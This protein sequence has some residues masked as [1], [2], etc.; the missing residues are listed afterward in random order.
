MSKL[1]KALLMGA[2][3]VLVTALAIGG[4]VAYLTDTDSDVNVMTLGNVSIE[5]LRRQR[6]E[7]TDS[8]ISSDNLETF[9]NHKPLLPSVY[10]QMDFAANFQQW[11]TGGSSAMFTDSMKNVQDNIVFVHNTGKTNAYVRTWFA[12]E[13]GSMTTEQFAKTIGININDTHWSGWD[14][15]F[16]DT[17]QIVTINNNNYALVCVTYTGNAGNS[18]DIHP[19]GVLAA[20]ETTR[21][22]LL[23]VMMYNTV[24]NED[25]EAIDGNNNGLYDVLV[26]S[27]AVQA[28]GFADASTA[29]NAA[30]GQINPWTDGDVVFEAPAVV[31]NVMNLSAHTIL[32]D[33][34]L[35]SNHTATEATT[36]NGNGYTV[37]MVA[38]NEQT[39]DWDDTFTIPQMAMVFS[40]ENGALV[41]V[42]DLNITGS[43]QSVMAGNYEKTN[44]GRHNTVFNNV[45][46]IDT[47]VVSLSANISPALTV[48]G[49]LT[50]NN[51]NVYGAKL[52]SLD[53]DPM[54][55]VYDMAVTNFSDTTINGGRIGS[56]YTWAK[57][58]VE[59]NNARIDSIISACRSTNDFNKGGLVIGSGTTIDSIKVTNAKAV[60]TIK[61]GAVVENLD[62]SAVTTKEGVTI[63]NGAIVKNITV[64][65]NTIDYNTWKTTN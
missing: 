59:I 61:S 1:K 31:N 64:N 28:D 18:S 45:N 43:M 60:L 30:F 58:H 47:E 57:S 55:P 4:T 15:L 14:K 38:S 7:Q 17:N 10:E 23:Q 56:I 54:W 35:Y 20:G 44:Q 19:G 3:Y 40:S 46:I 5:Q 52:S 39:F 65:G 33:K 29:L 24:T 50:M 36:I 41:T 49:K 21:P 34:P 62:L 42:N 32:L 37:T 9:Q 16:A 11:P 63:E 8:N 22:S 53:T 27:Q 13:V 48:Y 51:C 2:A 25:V 6:K 26:F 12:F